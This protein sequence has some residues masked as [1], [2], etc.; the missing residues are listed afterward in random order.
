MANLFE[1]GAKLLRARERTI[2]ECEQILTDMKMHTRN[3]RAAYVAGSSV[4]VAGALVGIGATAA[5]LITGPIGAAVIVGYV[6]TGTGIAGGLVGAGTKGTEC[7]LKKKQLNQ[8]KRCIDEERERMEEFSDAMNSLQKDVLNQGA[9]VALHALSPIS[10]AI[11]LGREIARSSTVVTT[12]EFGDEIASMALTSVYAAGDDVTI[13][14]GNASKV[15]S[16]VAKYGGAGIQA[17][18]AGYAIYC[19]VQDVRTLQ[20]DDPTEQIK[21]IEVLLQKMQAE[22]DTWRE[23]LAL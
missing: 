8:L 5:I 20:R 18:F 12:S 6:A 7:I 23:F 10:N 19:L 11:K 4:G 22:L 16:N 15:M 9:Y 14:A 21:T 1:I 13:A 17:A 2:E 3:C